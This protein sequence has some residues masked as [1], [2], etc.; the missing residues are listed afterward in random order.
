MLRD[1]YI[2]CL[3]KYYCQKAGRPWGSTIVTADVSPE[4]K[5]P[6]RGVYH[7][8]PSIAEAETEKDNISTTP[9]VV[10]LP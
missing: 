7:P 9:G 10:A 6:G 8:P 3:V 4:V 5:W 1:T 2:A